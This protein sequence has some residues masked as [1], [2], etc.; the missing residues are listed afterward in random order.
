MA[1]AMI[2][3]TTPI[4]RYIARVFVLTFEQR[5]GGWSLGSVLAAGVAV[6]VV[7]EA[8]VAGF[9][10]MIQSMSCFLQM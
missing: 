3:A 7:V 8:T 9:R 5:C 6:A 10:R 4:T 2:M 1:T